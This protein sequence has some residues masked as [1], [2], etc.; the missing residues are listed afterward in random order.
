MRHV[1]VVPAAWQPAQRAVQPTRCCA[2]ASGVLALGVR[3]ARSW[4]SGRTRRSRTPRR[5]RR[6][7]RRACS[8]RRCPRPRSVWSAHC[9]GWR[10][11]GGRPG[12]RP[13][14]AA[15]DEPRPAHHHRMAER[16][17]VRHSEAG[18][19]LLRT[20]VIAHGD[21]ARAHW[22]PEL[23]L[24]PSAPP[25]PSLLRLLRRS[26]PNQRAALL[27]ERDQPP[28]MWLL[29]TRETVSYAKIRPQVANVTS[30]TRQ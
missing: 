9:G 21:L 22:P 12:P 14:A 5:G 26:G 28:P 16:W 6:S 11:A 10:S 17:G 24:A 15:G 23:K 1:G 18:V 30:R 13:H 19:D 2:D 25:Q 29:Q 8:S 7:S 4:R 20:R 3:R 27:D